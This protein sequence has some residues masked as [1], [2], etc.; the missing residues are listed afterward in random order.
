VDDLETLARLF[1]ELSGEES[2]VCKMKENFKLIGSNRVD[3]KRRQL[4]RRIGDGDY[5]S[6]FSPSMQTIYAHRE[7]CGEECLARER[8][9]SKLMEEIEEIG[10]QRECYYTMFVSGSHRK[11][12]HQFYKS[13]GYDL[14]MV[15]GFK[16]YLF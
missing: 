6:R 2:D 13:V 5:L 7:C 10:Q 16:K 1:E 8:D 4:S 11:E 9:W 14:D 15:Q 12:A 3:G